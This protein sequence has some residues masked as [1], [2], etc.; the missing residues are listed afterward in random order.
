MTSTPAGAFIVLEGPDKSGKSTQAA[1]LVRA[2]REHYARA[3]SAREIV[4]TREPGGTSFAEAVR[5]VVL[6]PK[7]VVEPLAELLLYEAARAQ[8]TEQILRPA[9]QAGCVVISERYTM[10]TLAYQGY[11]RGLDLALVRELNCIAAGG[12]AADLTVLLDLPE[13]HF[14][15]RDPDRDL[16]RLEKETSAFRRKVRQGYRKLAETEP[17]AL[18]LDARR[19]P[20]PIHAELTRHV[21]LLLGETIEPLPLDPHLLQSPT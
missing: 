2:L 17:G 20:H 12:L 18:K 11:A 10:A 1:L 14:D 21:S 9:L 8:H 4:H 13:T 6:D 3:G 7:H 16:D 19:E 5:S 15:K